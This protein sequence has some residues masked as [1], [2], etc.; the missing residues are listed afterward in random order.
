MLNEFLEA[1]QILESK[2]KVL[3]KVPL[4]SFQNEISSWKI[5]AKEK[6]ISLSE[7]TDKNVL[8]FDLLENKANPDKDLLLI[9]QNILSQTKKIA[10]FPINQLKTAVE[11]IEI[12]FNEDTVYRNIEASFCERRLNLSAELKKNSLS[13][14]DI[15][16]L[17]A[18]FTR[19]KGNTMS[20]ATNFVSNNWDYSL[21]NDE[22]FKS[23]Q[24]INRINEKI[25][26]KKA[27]NPGTFANVSNNNNFSLGKA[28]NNFNYNFNSPTESHNSF[29]NSLNF[30]E[31]IKETNPK[32]DDS[33]FLLATETFEFSSRITQNPLSATNKSTKPP[34]KAVFDNE[35]PRGL[36]TIEE[37]TEKTPAGSTKTISTSG[38]YNPK[39]FLIVN[40]R[41]SSKSPFRGGNNNVLAN[42]SLE[43]ANETDNNSN[44]NYNN[45]KNLVSP[46]KSATQFLQ[47]DTNTESFSNLDVSTD[48]KLNTHTSQRKLAMGFRLNE[49]FLPVFNGLRNDL[50]EVVDFTCADLG[51]P[52]IAFLAEFFAVSTNM[53]SLKLVKNKISDDGVVVLCKALSTNY[54]LANLNLTLNLL[55][56]KA[57]DSFF[58]LI[59]SNSTLKN[60]YLLQNNISVNKTKQKVKEFKTVG[61][62]LFI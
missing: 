6:L 21:T 31:L 30:Q 25:E 27:L 23:R 29:I 16:S 14:E 17:E 45:I 33:E 22:V 28:N 39:T 52:G 1:F 13:N 8:H 48:K 62:N 56:D 54:S 42:T 57:I 47:K 34:L 60:I 9:G 20:T 51:D 4:L 24:S 41:A 7:K 15:K 2:L 11:N 55:S 59:K 35:K 49:K 5:S 12:H 40:K 50:L 37:K 46:M 61:T 38:H 26:T 36:Q 3:K 58:A 43:K 18:Y 10:G 19:N 44:Y 53:K 32:L